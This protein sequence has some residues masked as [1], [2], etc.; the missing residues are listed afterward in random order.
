MH[1]DDL[2]FI[3]YG[4]YNNTYTCVY[5]LISFDNNTIN[6]RQLLPIY[7]AFSF[8]VIS[9]I[10]SDLF[11][12]PSLVSQSSPSQFFNPSFFFF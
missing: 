10:G 12:L 3:P 6:N 8:F 1:I 9:A 4:V 2:Y 5:V 7:V 11:S